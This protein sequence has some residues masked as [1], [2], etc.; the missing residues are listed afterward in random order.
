MLLWIFL[1][2]F[3]PTLPAMLEGLPSQD[4]NLYKFRWNFQ[5]RAFRARWLVQKKI[6]SSRYWEALVDQVWL[7]QQNQWSFQGLLKRSALLKLV[8]QHGPASNT[9]L[10]TRLYMCK[11]L[12]DIQMPRRFADERRIQRFEAFFFELKSNI[13]PNL[14]DLNW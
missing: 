5:Y 7:Y 10:H 8:Y 14:V 9:W 4:E 6:S 13:C 12:Y 1:K 2:L 3:W 11:S